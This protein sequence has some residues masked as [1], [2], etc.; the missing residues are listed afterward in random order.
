MR[1]LA[2]TQSNGGTIM[3][4][5]SPAFGPTKVHKKEKVHITALNFRKSPFFFLNSKTGQNTS[6]NF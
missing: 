2:K 6:L 1:K 4:A 5:R 3:L